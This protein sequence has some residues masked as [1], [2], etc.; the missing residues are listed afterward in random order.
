M[1]RTDLERG[2]VDDIVEF[3][4]L[5]KHLVEGC[6]VRDIDVVVC[7]ALSGDELNSSHTFLGRVVKVVD[8]DDVVA[9]FDECEGGEGTNVASAT[10]QV[11][12]GCLSQVA[13]ACLGRTRAEDLERCL[14]RMR[15][16]TDMMHSPGNED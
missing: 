7:R 2:E 12:A 3:W 8:N 6:L 16:A 1:S 15:F 5:G 11:L 9:G 10:G 13:V 14:D 4:V